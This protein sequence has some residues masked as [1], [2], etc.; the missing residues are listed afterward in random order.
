[1]RFDAAVIGAGPAGSAAARLLAQAEWSVAL[2]EKARFPRRKVCG[3]FISATSLP[4]LEACGVA[5]SFLAA[6][7]PPV[8]RIAGW[9]GERMV[10]A[11]LP[12]GAYGRA[13][14]R[15]HLD[16]MLRDAAVA[17]GAR[18]FQPA[19]VTD[20][21]RRAD[22]HA[23]ILS[24]NSQA[25]EIEARIVIAACGSWNAKGPFAVERAPKPSDLFAFKAH[26]RNS[27]LPPGMMPMLAFPG[28]Y[29]GMT[30]SDGGRVTL[31]CCIR[32]DALARARE[33]QGGKAAEAV[34]AHIVAHTKG[35]RQALQD[36]VP[37]GAFLSTGPI[38]PGIRPRHRD[39]IFFTG[40]IAGEAHPIIAEGISMA[41]QTSGLLAQHLIASESGAATE[42]PH[43]WKKQFGGRIH[44]ASMFAHLAMHG[45]SRAA[46]AR[47]IEIF[48][49]LLTW[50]AAL[51][52]KGAPCT[53]PRQ[54]NAAIA[55]RHDTA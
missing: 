4:V 18:L 10:E 49:G 34:F 21:D 31:S 20:L 32:R 5:E 52:G 8:T 55:V 48:P 17:M 37:E 47:L 36:S 12:W 13:L 26:F 9:A 7:G 23:I 29:G 39:G 53:S 24:A 25:Q 27:A 46:A 15:E 54:R 28:G 11:P 22:G 44:A 42:Y 6:A 45:T 1:M 19:E 2:V 40:N 43:A 51:S 41:I 14:G 30:H 3:E 35:V 33:R 38:H 50:G 16:V